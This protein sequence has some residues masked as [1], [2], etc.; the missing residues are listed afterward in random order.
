M[1]QSQSSGS[2][3]N[4]IIGGFMGELK[5]HCGKE[6]VV[7][8]A[9]TDDNLGRR[10]YGCGDRNWKSCNFFRWFDVEKPHG[11]Q[12]KALVEARDTIQD[13]LQELKKL[14]ALVG[15][16]GEVMASAGEQIESRADN[17]ENSEVWIELTNENKAL[18]EEL[19]LSVEKEKLC[20]Q[21]VVISWVGFVCVT[22]IICNAFK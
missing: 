2:A 21:F 12:K 10:F 20:R 3:S 13:Q 1:N 9:W 14:R 17:A 22:A 8:K 5:C 7:K 18:K 6:S 11:W 16:D 4:A 15:E 19:A